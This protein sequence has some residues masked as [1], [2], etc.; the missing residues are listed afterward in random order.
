MTWRK[1]SQ[2]KYLSVHDM[3][4]ASACTFTFAI[5]RALSLLGTHNLLQKILHH[6]WIAQSEF[7]YTYVK[8]SQFLPGFLINSL[9]A[10]PDISIAQTCEAK[11]ENWQHL[12]CIKWLMTEWV[13]DFFL[14]RAAAM[15]SLVVDIIFLCLLKFTKKGV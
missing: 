5:H 9:T 11:P 12:N 2:F 14:W 6:H 1:K 8:T 3:Q 15:A 7:I 13:S 4:C 10:R